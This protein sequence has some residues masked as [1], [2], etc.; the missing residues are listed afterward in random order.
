[1]KKLP[2]SPRIGISFGEYKDRGVIL[3][4]CKNLPKHH[5]RELEIGP[6]YGVSYESGKYV[7]YNI[8]EIVELLK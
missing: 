6:F 8:K 1:M 7:W 3:Q 5:K 2:P 4:S